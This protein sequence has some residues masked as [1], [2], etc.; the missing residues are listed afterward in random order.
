M[1]THL[2]HA[3]VFVKDQNEALRFY[4]EKLGFEV[5]ADITLEGYRWLTVGAKGQPDLEIIL[6]ALQPGGGMT[7]EGVKM[8]TALLDSGQIGAG[9][10]RTDNCQKTYEELKEKGVEFLNPPTERPYGV[11]AVFKD[12]SGNWFSLTEPRPMAE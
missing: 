12:N 5:R 1:I 9:V 10:L 4:T 6:T 2:S 11:E 7:E 3:G 8:Y